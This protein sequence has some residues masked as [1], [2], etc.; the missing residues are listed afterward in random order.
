MRVPRVKFPSSH[1]DEDRRPPKPTAPACGRSATE[2]DVCLRPP[3]CAQSIRTRL[4][5]WRVGVMARTILAPAPIRVASRGEHHIRYAHKAQVRRLALGSFFSLGRHRVPSPRRTP[6]RQLGG[7]I[8]T[9]GPLRAQ[10]CALR[11]DAVLAIA[12]E[13]DD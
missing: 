4:S 12:P 13:R 6:V 1:L 2:A 8:P 3:P 9:T 10:H 11:H 5:H 7:S